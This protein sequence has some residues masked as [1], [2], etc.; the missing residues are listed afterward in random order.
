M[1]ASVQIDEKDVGLCQQCVTELHEKTNHFPEAHSREELAKLSMEKELC[2]ATIG[3]VGDAIPPEPLE[4]D[5]CAICDVEFNLEEG[6]E[7]GIVGT[8]H[9]SLCPGCYHGLIEMMAQTCTP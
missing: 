3:L 4:P 9:V 5:V 2:F 8:L 6:G 1:V 7:E